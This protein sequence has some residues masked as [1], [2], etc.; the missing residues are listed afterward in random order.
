MGKSR[1]KRIPRNALIADVVEPDQ[2]GRVYL[3]AA[4]WK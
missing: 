4:V 2:R 3:A 1:M